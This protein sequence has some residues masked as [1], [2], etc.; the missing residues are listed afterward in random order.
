VRGELIEA[1]TRLMA[2]DG[3]DDQV[4][5]RA[6]ARQAGVAP[7][8]F[9]LHFATIDELLWD[10]YAREYATLTERSTS[11]AHT[12]RDPYRRLF[13]GCQAYCQFTL[14]HPSQTS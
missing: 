10:V 1:A 13:A 4:T 6:V 2:A 8:S 9:Y 12:A 7:Q 14:E 11:A 3:R 5:V